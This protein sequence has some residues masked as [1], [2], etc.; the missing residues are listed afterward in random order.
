MNKQWSELNK[1]M[2]SQIKKKD[3]FSLGIDTLI[4]LRKELMEQ[5][6]QLKKS[7]PLLILVLC[8]I[9]MQTVII[10]K[11]FATPYG[12]FFESKILLY[13]H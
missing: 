13:I 11:R 6:L 12:I 7:C 5:I 9:G 10:T 1:T 4:N 3:T 2:Q 8:R